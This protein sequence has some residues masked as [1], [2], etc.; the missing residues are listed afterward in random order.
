MRLRDPEVLRSK[1]DRPA[2]V[3]WAAYKGFS[4]ERNGKMRCVSLTRGTTCHCSQIA[5][6]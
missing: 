1:P 5:A 3:R 6:R 4:A 2:K